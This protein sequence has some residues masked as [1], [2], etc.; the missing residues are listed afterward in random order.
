MLS[1]ISFQMNFRIILS[2]LIERRFGAF[3]F[4]LNLYVSLEEKMTSF[5]RDLLSD[6]VGIQLC[7]A[8]E[9]LGSLGSIGGT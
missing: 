5:S 2:Y 4:K 7:F 9:C 3:E 6:V 1:P 8:Q